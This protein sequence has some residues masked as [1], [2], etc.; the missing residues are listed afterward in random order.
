M[1]LLGAS[2]PAAAGAFDLLETT[3]LASS[4]SSVTFSGLDAYSDYK[5]LQ[6]RV[7]A[8]TDRSLEAD[9]ILMRL[10]SDSGSNYAHHRLA[11]N[12]TSVSVGAGSSQTSIKDQFQLA[13]NT[14]SSGIFGAGV[15]DILDFSSS[16]KNT[17]T[18][19]LGG[20]HTVTYNAIM[21]SSGLWV[22][23]DA[24][25]SILLQPTTGP[26]FITGSRFSLYG[27]K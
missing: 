13:G 17:T 12:G 20:S 14:A 7:T 19:S 4:A 11:G 25:T 9:G 22:N 24:V 16:T 1:G 10:N 8:R 5:H 27:V 15:F 23:T 3:T 6:I 21:L 2:A 26:N 18:R